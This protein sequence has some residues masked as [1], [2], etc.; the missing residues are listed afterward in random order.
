MRRRIG[1]FLIVALWLGAIAAPAQAIEP[2]TPAPSAQPTQPVRTGTPPPFPRA[3]NNKLAKGSWIVQLKAGAN[4]TAKAGANL[5]AKALKLAKAERGSVGKVYSHAFK[6]FQFKG[7]AKQAAALR[8]DPSVASVTKDRPITL[9][10]TDPFGIERID[11]FVVGGG[12]AYSAGYRG[13]GARIAVIDTGIDLTH[14]DLK[15]SIDQ[16]SGWNCVNPGQ[17]PNDGYGHGTHVAGIAAAPLNGV[18]VVGVAPEA[19]LVPIKTFDDSGNSSEALVLCGIDRV[20]ALNTDADPSNDIDVANMSWGETRSWGSCADD[21]LHG[22]ICA[23][24][25]AGVVLVGGAGNDSGDAGQ[26]VP[27]AFPEVI[28][29]SAMADFDGKPGG[30]GGCQFLPSLLWTQCDDALAFFSNRGPSVDV[31]APGVNVYS[32]WAGGGYKSESGTSMATPHVSGVAAL[33]RAVN[34]TLTTAQARTILEETGELPDGSSAASGCGSATQ[35]SGDTDGIA[36]PLVNALRAAQRAANPTSGTA[37]VLTLSP[38]EGA[39][40]SGSVSLSATASHSSGIASVE[41]FVDGASVAKDTTAP[42]S[43]SWDATATFDGVH[44][45]RAMATANRGQTAV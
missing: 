17:P 4:L 28:S 9:A 15:A 10:E 29:V 5:T 35:W 6:G 3:G 25:A 42:Y 38:A 21:A 13:A 26:F 40:V 32:T 20:I 34:P 41:F 8:R 27:A 39:N 37:P 7:S 30:L 12:D 36:E 22:A 43:A 14:P 45:V 19:T 16:A 33:M 44:V 31:T 2:Q 23:A 11:A 1:S 24:D 18:G